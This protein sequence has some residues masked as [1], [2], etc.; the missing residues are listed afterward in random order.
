VRERTEQFLKGR[1]MFVVVHVE[2]E[3]EGRCWCGG[4]VKG[5]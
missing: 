3:G 2:R 5:G 4:G 1:N